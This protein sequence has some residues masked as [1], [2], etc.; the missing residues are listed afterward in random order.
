MSTATNDARQSLRPARGLGRGAG[1]CRRLAPARLRIADRLFADRV[2]AGLFP[3]SAGRPRRGA[4]C[5]GH[6]ADAGKRSIRRHPLPGRGPLQETGRHLLAAGS[7]GESGRGGRHPAGAH[8][9]LAVPA[10]VAVRGH[11]RRA[12]DLLDRARLCRA[13]HRAA[14]GADDGEFGPA[15]RRGAAG[16]DRR[17]AAAHLRGGDGRAGAYLSD[18]PPHT[19]PC[20]R[21][22]A[23]G[24][25]MDR[26]GGRRAHQGAVDPD[27]RRTR[28]ARAVDR[29]PFRPLDLVAASA[30]RPGLVDRAGAA[31]VRRHHRQVRW[32][33]SRA[34]G[35]RG[36]AGQG[37]RRTG[38]A[39]RAAGILLSAVLGDVLAGLGAGGTGR[40]AGMA[41]AARAGR[42]LSAGVA[43]A[44]LGGVRRR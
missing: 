29:R 2:P 17:R 19:G 9:H 30:R 23:A 26:A 27:V 42:A 40:A 18:E 8:H 15:R 31:L 25:P 33:F 35:W 7:G 5:A 21:L 13:P 41:G 28:R 24:D 16:Q 4:L 1:L 44:V 22:A 12:A 10:A 38:I 20:R 6:Q 39:W 43:A 3:D 37:D 32:Q 11:R 36:H 14:G 34:V